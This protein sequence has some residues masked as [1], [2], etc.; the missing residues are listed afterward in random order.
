M[1][2]YSLRRRLLLW[3]FLA[4]AVLGV[5][6]LTDTWQ[7]ARRTAQGVSDR[8]LAGS[9]LAIAERVTLNA[10][11][12]LDVD[13]PYAALEMLT[14]TAQDQVFYRVD[15]PEGKLLTGYESLDR[16]APPDAHG[17]FF[18]DGAQ[19]G[20][21]LRIVTLTREL[22]S[23][24]A[25]I[26]FSVTV[27]E[28]T[29]ARE[30]LARAILLR[31]A[32]RLIALALA[33]AVIVWVA[34]TL[35]LRPLNRLGDM[36]ALRSP[37]DL[38]PVSGHT[39]AE[40]AGLIGAIN[41]F[42]WRL[43]QALTALRNFTGN[44]SHQLRT[45]LA[46]LRTELAMAARSDDP[47]VRASAFT[48]AEAALVRAER[49]LAQLLL[50]AHVDAAAG[51]RTFGP[52][53]IAALARR[54]TADLVPQAARAG[55]DL[56]YE[57]PQA[58]FVIGD[59]TLIEEMLHNLIDNAVRYAGTGA[60]VTVQ[61]D[62]GT[63]HSILRVEDTGRGLTAAQMEAL[64]APVRDRRQPPARNGGAAG[65]GLGLPIVQEIAALLGAAASF[66]HT[67]GGRGLRVS[68][69]FARAPSL[70]PAAKP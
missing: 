50:L 12:G 47:Q 43:D 4:T 31:S 36:I 51:A 7:E 32:T 46:A 29:R 38:A 48:R 8:V 25:P 44:A 13:L 61:V 21:S 20:S 34:V 52:I 60:N 37:E 16:A 17:T 30:A 65:M 53:D 19:G 67:A 62:E 68:L 41:G 22:S 56:G 69:R 40:V 39:P 55:I 1:K 45:P 28:S 18:A 49:V 63:D 70:Q 64:Q 24:D 3:L 6:A 2:V 10:D 54:L 33:G 26:A 58:A 15:G 35:A 59:P 14:S 23:G 27:A 9:A 66:D 57:G 5:A 42:M 11:G